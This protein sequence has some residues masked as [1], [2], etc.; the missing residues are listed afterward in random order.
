LPDLSTPKARAR[1]ATRSSPYTQKLGPGRF[2]AYRRQSYGNAGVW[3][4]RT[5]KATGGYAQETLAFADDLA[6]AD[7]IEVLTFEQAMARAIGQTTADPMQVQVA[8]ALDDWA[9]WKC[10]TASS[11][12]QC[13]DLRNRAARLAQ[14]FPRKTLKT[15]TARDVRRW[16]D[17]MVEG[18]ENPQARR[19]TANRELAV[20]KAAL[21]RAADLHDYQGTRAWNRVSKFS[22]AEAFGRRMVVLNPAEEARLIEAARPDLAALLT[23]LQ[24][25]GCRCGEIA[26]ATVGD[27]AGDRLTVTGKTGTRT[28]VLSA[29]K[30]EWFHTQAG[31]RAQSEPLLRRQDGAAW[32]DGGHLKPMRIA[33]AAAGLSDDVTAYA[34]RHGFITRALSRGVPTVAVAQHCGTSVEMIERTYAN[35][36]GSQLATWFA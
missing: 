13:M 32:P 4:L 18:A 2:L 29:E 26:S 6:A 17:A 9:A 20:L 14:A 22:K 30:A 28:I 23:A 21:N 27:L 10:G 1:L 19:A 31:N 34:F 36:T 25:T 7:G 16:L 35:F 12:K 5:T 24:M 11:P 8:E 3:L 33:V 15:I